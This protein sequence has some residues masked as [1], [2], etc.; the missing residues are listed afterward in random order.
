MER[1][2][3]RYDL[4]RWIYTREVIIRSFVVPHSHPVLTLNTRQLDDDDGLLGTFLHEQ[5]HWFESSRREFAEQAIAEF[6]RIYPEVPV[7]GTEGATNERSSY[8]HLIICTLE[9]DALAQLLGRDRA[10]RVVCARPYYRWVYRRVT[11][12]EAKIKPV[13][14]RHSLSLEHATKAEDC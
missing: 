4:D 3:E 10:T 6:R 1:L 11:E 5:F 13:L 9:F 8:L 14:E 7:G 12:D 2:L